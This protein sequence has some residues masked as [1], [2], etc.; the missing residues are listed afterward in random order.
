M[1]TYGTHIQTNNILFFF[2]CPFCFMRSCYINNVHTVFLD[3]IMQFVFWSKLCN[4]LSRYSLFSFKLT[5]SQKRAMNLSRAAHKG[6]LENLYFFILPGLTCIHNL[7]LSILAITMQLLSI[8][9]WCTRNKSPVTY[10]M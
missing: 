9:N 10:W 4:D 1:V 6:S 7:F 2:S 3:W 5:G 8:R